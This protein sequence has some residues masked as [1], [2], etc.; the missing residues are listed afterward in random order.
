LPNAWLGGVKNI[1]LIKEF[2]TDQG[3]WKSFADGVE[4][5]GVVDGFLKI[6]LKE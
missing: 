5:I 2:G 3:F 6:Q 4:T 1:D